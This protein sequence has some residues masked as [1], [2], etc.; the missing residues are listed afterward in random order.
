MKWL[1]KSEEKMNTSSDKQKLGKEYNKAV[2][3]HPFYLTY[4]QTTSC[5]TPDWI[6]HKLESRISITSE[7][8]LKSG[9]LQSKG[10][11]RVGHD[12]ATELNCCRWY[13]SSGTKQRGTRESLD[14][15]ERQEWKSWLETQYSKIML[16]GPITLWQ[17]DGEKVEAVTDFFLGFQNHCGWWLQP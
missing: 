3:C 15:S 2:Y 14:E 13:H 11:Q 6:K 16:S 8:Q 12:W 4:M 9:V 1:F 5:K 10:L 7:M 17:I